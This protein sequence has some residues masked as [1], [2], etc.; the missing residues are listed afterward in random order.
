LFI[1]RFANDSATPNSKMKTILV[2]GKPRLCLFA[3]EMIAEGDEI[4][5]DYGV[6]GLPWREKVTRQCIM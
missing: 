6:K 3:T 2:Y 1:Y 5:Y 4:V